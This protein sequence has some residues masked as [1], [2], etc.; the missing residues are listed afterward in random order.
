MEGLDLTGHQA[1]LGWISQL[2]HRRKRT[3]AQDYL[4]F[5]AG[6]RSRPPRPPLP[7]A[8]GVEQKVDRLLVRGPNSLSTKTIG[9]PERRPLQSK[10]T[11]PVVE[12]DP[13][14]PDES[15]CRKSHSEGRERKLDG[16][17]RP[18]SAN[19]GEGEGSEPT[20]HS[21]K[22]RSFSSLGCS[23]RLLNA[24]TRRGL[25]TISDLDPIRFGRFA[26]MRGV[27]RKS[28][29]ELIDI[30]VRAGPEP[31]SEIRL[32]ED[33]NQ[34][35]TM[36]SLQLPSEVVA[37]LETVGL[38]TIGDLQEA[39]G[40]ADAPQ[41][42][43]ALLSFSRILGW[44]PDRHDQEVG[45][46]A[47]SA[48]ILLPRWDAYFS[49]MSSTWLNVPPR[50]L[51]ALEE[52]GVVSIADVLAWMQSQ[53]P[54]MQEQINQAVAELTSLLPSALR[55]AAP[56]HA[57]DPAC[58][59]RG[60]WSQLSAAMS[61]AG[62]D[63]E[64][65][66]LAPGLSE[67]DMDIW[68]TRFPTQSPTRPTLEAL[69]EQYSISR[70]RVRQLEKR[71]MER[72]DDSCFRLPKWTKFVN[73]LGQSSDPWSR[74]ELNEAY[75]RVGG[76]LSLDL[77]A[78]IAELSARGFVPPSHLAEECGVLFVGLSRDRWIVKRQYQK[79]WEAFRRAAIR[80]T[81]Q[82]GFVRRIP[83][84]LVPKHIQEAMI[85]EIAGRGI[86]IFRTP[87]AW[88]FDPML[89]SSVG[90]IVRKCFSVSPRMPIQNIASAVP[91]LVRVGE[92]KEDDVVQVITASSEFRFD[93]PSSGILT[94]HGQPY[95]LSEAE[96]D[97]VE[98][99]RHQG[100]ITSWVDMR[101][102]LEKRG[103]STPTVNNCLRMPWFTRVSSGIYAMVGHQDDRRRISEVKAALRARP[104]LV[105][106]DEVI[107]EGIF[108][109][110]YSMRGRVADG[111]L[112]TPKFLR[113]EDAEWRVLSGERQAIAVTVRNG[114]A[115][116]IR[117]WLES[118]VVT[119]DD[120]LGALF[121]LDDRTIELSPEADALLNNALDQYDA[122]EFSSADLMQ[123]IGGHGDASA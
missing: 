52:D 53:R 117:E 63:A 88:Y 101:E 99:A 50:L 45:E 114:F 21:A 85:K 62:L 49:R 104:S 105:I 17:T 120:T 77:A 118:S 35:D 93:P 16:A 41:T 14:D 47:A 80:Q 66:S 76:E 43:K 7:W 33:V 90:R 78:V 112:P 54:D 4:E 40:T 15:L 119:E 42:V 87:R 5:R 107:T 74:E 18:L 96:A 13:Q 69:G 97:S 113:E 83:H 38:H 8:K 11:E 12:R 10:S 67:R 110:E 6:I 116:S 31:M 28:L 121:R 111:V 79:Y 102:F 86:V 98:F 84:T 65:K 95:P 91:Y 37:G 24:L 82:L 46:L 58:A 106:R 55:V 19:D 100:G 61:S 123:L 32:S 39:L 44:S 29:A 115:W 103:W 89:P 30:V 72:V 51:S 20:N 71:A 75:K 73:E 81:R 56:R 64:L 48:E 60:T 108:F 34:N 94:Y 26:S 22:G 122:E 57:G 2:I 1:V 25:H 9:A 3:Y 36:T 109:V 59:V 92:I 70:E 68:L 23:R 27:G